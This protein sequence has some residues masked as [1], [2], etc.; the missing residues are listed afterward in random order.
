MLPVVEYGV[1][2][3]Q[4]QVLPILRVQRSEDIVMGTVCS[5]RALSGAGCYTM[6]PDSSA[7][8]DTR[9]Q[10]QY[11]GTAPTTPLNQFPG[12]DEVEAL[13]WGA[14]F[15]NF[16]ENLKF[17]KVGIPP[18]LLEDLPLVIVTLARSGE[19]TVWL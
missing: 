3:N 8:P 9:L 16:L 15:R 10:Y 11:L 2:Y 13:R 4:P 12:M 18:Y 5:I 1:T 7:L 6:H 17:T 19:G 14:K